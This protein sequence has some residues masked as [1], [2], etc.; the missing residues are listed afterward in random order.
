[1]HVHFAPGVLFDLPGIDELSGLF[2]AEL[3]AALAAPLPALEAVAAAGSTGAGAQLAAPT[4]PVQ[5][6]RDG[7][8]VQRVPHGRLRRP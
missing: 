8:T 6:V 5:R 4:R 7:R 1:M 3:E 2:G